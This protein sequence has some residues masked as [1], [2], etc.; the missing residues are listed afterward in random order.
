MSARGSCLAVLAALCGMALAAH[1]QNITTV[2]GG[3]PNNLPKLAA[4]LNFASGIAQDSSGN[5]YLAS[6][7]DNRIYKIDTTGTLTIFAGTG[8]RSFGGDGGPATQADIDS[9]VS[10]FVDTNN[11]VFIPD[12]GNLVIRRVDA[13]THIITTVAGNVAGTICGTATD[14][15]GDGCPATSAT[16]PGGPFA[17]DVDSKGDLFIADTTDCAVRE[18]SAATG[19]IQ[20][21]AGIP[22]MCST[23]G[24]GG[25]ATEAHL[26]VVWNLYVDGS[27]NIF[28]VDYEVSE[29]REVVAATG[30]I[31]LVAGNGS[32]GYN[33]DG[34]LATAA[35]L[36]FPQGVIADAA[37]NVYIAD[38]AN[39]RIRVVG[40]P[41][42][43]MPGYI[44]SVAGNGTFGFSGDNGPATA[45][46]LNSPFTMYLDGSGN[47]FIL[48]IGNSRV[49]EVYCLESSVPCTPPAGSAAGEI[50]TF[51]GNGL[52]QF[53]G[54]GYPA[55]DGALASPDAV[56]SDAKGNLYVSDAGNNV[57][58][59]VDGTTHNLSTIAGNAA[60]LCGYTGDGGP[61]TA[62]LLCD[63]KGLFTDSMGNVFIADASNDAIREIVAATGQIQTV[64]GIG[65]TGVP[66]ATATN[67]IGDG[68]PATQSV[69]LVPAGVF[70]DSGGNLYIADTGNQVIRKVSAATG[71]IQT[72]A[73]TPLTA[74]YGGDGGLATAAGALL[75]GPYNVYVDHSGNLF[76]SD[77]DNAVVR[78][79][80]GPSGASP[81]TIQTVIG[82]PDNL[83]Y[84]GDG[85]PATLATTSGPFQVIMDG[86]GD[87]FVSDCGAFF[88]QQETCNDTVR[89]VSAATGDIQTVAGNGMFGFSGDG[90]PATAAELDFVNGIALDPLGNLL[91]ADYGNGRV[92]SVAMLGM[93]TAAAM[94]VTVIPFD[95]TTGT[96]PITVTFSN[97][98]T[99]GTTSLTTGSTGPPAPSSFE[100]GTPPVYYN[101]STTASYSGTITVCVNYTG[102][103]FPSGTPSLWHYSGGAWVNITTSVNTTTMVVCGTTTSLSPF[104]LFQPVPS[105]LP[106]VA[107]AG[108]PQTNVQCSSHSGTP[109]T[110]N[111]SASSDP[112]GEALTYLWTGP[113]GMV[114]G[115]TAV[116][117]VTAPLG[118]T[119][120]TLTV[121][122]TSGLSAMAQT[123][124]TVIDTI[125]PVLTLAR[126]RIRE[127]LPTATATGATVNLAGIATATDVCDAAP[128]ITNN[129]PALF[130]IGD[131]EVT[132]TATDHSGN[133]TQQELEV[134]IVYHFSGFFPPLSSEDHSESNRFEKGWSQGF[135]GWD[136]D[137]PTF[138]AGSTIPVAFQLRA[139]NGGI[140][141][142]ATATLE[143]FLVVESASGTVLEPIPPV[144]SGGQSGAQFSFD[145]RFGVYIYDLDTKGYADGRYR[146]RV[147]INDGTHHDT[148]FSIRNGFNSQK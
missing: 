57:I 140:V 20:T 110:L 41:T 61:A 52:A 26:T 130:P 75:S 111:G 22:G 114:V 104:A 24:D 72:V 137:N 62:A 91:I 73:G 99:A 18:V 10:V 34:I 40:G 102:I 108:P 76:I 148:H 96:T 64:A 13:V 142:N 53:S 46:A 105:I 147:T 127:I 106:P 11:N 145:P 44:Q 103:S 79:V 9:P 48:D 92:R 55:T 63:P 49:R 43:A 50:Q 141:K 66:C 80:Q 74:G 131:T 82:Q 115:S 89:E 65:P 83:G 29:I 69:L 59:K 54:D 33:G 93:N 118:T 71:I 1:A 6:E 14:S 16:I 86:A 25:P 119:T 37:G 56:F 132:F 112:Q 17:V 78:E 144:S 94:N 42:S 123:Q 139:A 8:A 97:V 47:M 121:T 15:V 136:W 133:A 2:V 81:G 30:N 100:L 101:L 128:I 51:A 21:V 95:T 85:G 109:V 134:E 117:M 38:S 122:D 60:L 125:P 28:I 146:I 87:I 138:H 88:G 126:Q 27:D 70:A 5:F 19:V 58:R 12:T 4:N 39:S 23:G 107:N 129:A 84:T 120:Y 90:G 7:G 124:V 68:C 98:T 31:Q 143:V 32:H 116:V 67:S 35:E 45:A 113:G 135:W 3:G 77:M 36:N